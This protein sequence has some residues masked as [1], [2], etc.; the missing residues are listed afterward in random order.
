MAK[1][2]ITIPVFDG[3]NYDMWKKR[4]SMFLKLKKCEIVIARAK[5]EDDEDP[6]DENDLKAIN[7]MY[8][9]LSDRQ[10]E[11]VCEKTTAYEIIKKLDSLYLK[12]TTALQIVYRN[13]LEKLR[14]I[15]TTM[16]RWHSLVILKE[17]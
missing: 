11:F 16:I 3:E 4:I 8:S 9:A 1:N 7:Y 5:T 13:K 12:E 2:E 14:L 10:L 15:R 17:P 6:W